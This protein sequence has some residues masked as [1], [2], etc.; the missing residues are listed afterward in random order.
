[1][2]PMLR[3]PP[4]TPQSKQRAYHRHKRVDTSTSAVPSTTES[5]NLLLDITMAS[6]QSYYGRQSYASQGMSRAS[7]NMRESMAPLVDIVSPLDACVQAADACVD[8]VSGRLVLPWRHFAG[9]LNQDVRGGGRKKASW[10]SWILKLTA[11]RERLEEARA[12][13][14]GHGAVEEGLPSAA[15]EWT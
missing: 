5:T 10:R 6:R 1:M 7:R 4:P 2:W 3:Q 13:R 12:G 8:T 15:C 14:R 11:D 9:S